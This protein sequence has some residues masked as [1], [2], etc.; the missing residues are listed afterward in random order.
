MGITYNPSIVSSG[1]VLA[2]D[3][4]NPKSYPG[5][6]TTWTDLSGRGNNG[7]LVGSPTYS[8]SNG[9]EIILNGT[10]QYINVP[11]P[12]LSATNY[13][14]FCASR[15]NTSPSG[16]IINGYSNN[17]LVGHWGATT[18]NYYA[19]G[20][21]SS[22]SAGAG[23]TNYRIHSATGDISLDSYQ[24]FVNGTLTA[25]P[26]T[27]GSQGPNGFGIGRYAPGNS[28]YSNARVSFLFAYNR[29]LTA[30]EVSQNFNALRGRYGI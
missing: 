4:G 9:G 26:N 24:L 12:N 2:L 1:L 28:E 11:T 18:E 13:T 10:T 30:A 22:V 3:A 7:T 16:R 6:G 21:V 19:E 20:W 25:G 15:Y 23:D 29:V 17:W 8:S 14:V 5:S 27:G